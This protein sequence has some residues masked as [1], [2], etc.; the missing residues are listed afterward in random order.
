MTVTD[1]KISTTSLLTAINETVASGEYPC[2]LTG[3]A[4]FWAERN[5]TQTADALRVIKAH[6]ESLP[7]EVAPLELFLPWTDENNAEW[8]AYLLLT[9]AHLRAAVADRRF[10]AHRH[11]AGD[12]HI[13]TPTLVAGDLTID[14]SLTITA[15]QERVDLLV[16]GDLTIRG[17]FEVDWSKTLVLGDIRIDGALEEESEWSVIVSC[18]DLRAGAHVASSGELYVLGALASPLISVTYN[19]GHCTLIGGA[20]ALVF[21]ESDHAGSYVPGGVDAPVR[22]LA[23]IALED[24]PTGDQALAGLHAVLRAER[25]D[26]LRLPTLDGYDPDED[27]DEFIEEQTEELWGDFIEDVVDTL[28]EALKRGEPVFDD[29]ALARWRAAHGA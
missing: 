27:F 12:L 3:W 8:G 10:R 19:H 9:T 17:D 20:A 25:R 13:K 4:A 18:G 1:T 21:F 2:G 11:E 7:A 5:Y 15:T 22:A 24:E 6:L 14:G 29:A 28:L 23:E 16:L 26:A